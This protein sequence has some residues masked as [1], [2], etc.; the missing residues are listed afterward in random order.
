M[1][2]P[3]EKVC[4]HWVVAS[5]ECLECGAGER[6]LYRPQRLYERQQVAKGHC[7][8]CGRP[9]GRS[10]SK[11]RC[12]RCRKKATAAERRRLGTKPWVPG[13]R[14]RVPDAVRKEMERWM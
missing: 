5:R 13:S 14:G 2:W 4:E 9:R 1:T 11:T 7:M 10:T 3:K 6:K 12:A 8:N